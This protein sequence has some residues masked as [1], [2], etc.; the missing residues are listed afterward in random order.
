MARQRLH[1]PQT[2]NYGRADFGQIS[3]YRDRAQEETDTLDESQGAVVPAAS[4]QGTSALDAALKPRGAMFKGGARGVQNGGVMSPPINRTPG[5]ERGP[6]VNTGAQGGVGDTSA[7]FNPQAGTLSGGRQIDYSGLQKDYGWD[8]EKVNSTYGSLAGLADDSG[9]GRRQGS[10]TADAAPGA[11]TGGKATFDGKNWQGVN[12]TTDGGDFSRLSGFNAEK[13]NDLGNAT[14]DAMTSKYVFGR[15]ASKYDPADPQALPQIVAELNSMGI[16]A[17]YDGK[18]GIDFGDGYGYIDV[19]QAW[20]AEGGGGPFDWMPKGAAGGQA[21]PVMNA[22]LPQAASGGT[23]LQSL[24]AS[25]AVDPNDPLWAQ[26][27]R[28][29]QSGG[30][31]AL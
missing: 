15:V 27:L 28:N 29:L 5:G 18:D 14:N 7:Y 31:Q 26:I 10:A 19:Q 4:S 16:P 20:R 2:P 17:Q 6:M 23:N 22:L 21:Q 13:F 12:S 1:N 30:G 3:P 8:R 9:Y 25:G 24:L 11:A